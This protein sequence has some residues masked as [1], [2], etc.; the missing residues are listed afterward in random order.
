[1]LRAFQLTMPID[2]I[3]NK[4]QIKCLWMSQDLKTQV[5]WDVVKFSHFSFFI[6]YL[7][8]YSIHLLSLAERI[9]AVSRQEWNCF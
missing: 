3:E 8:F 5:S 4:K 6:W 9:G 2:E 1:M 7:E